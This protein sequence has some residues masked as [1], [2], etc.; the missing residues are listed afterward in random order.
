MPVDKFLEEA[1]CRKE[2]TIFLMQL[3]SS[4]IAFYIE[5]QAYK[6][7]EWKNRLLPASGAKWEFDRREHFSFTNM[8]LI[9]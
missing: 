1:I 8:S 7:R 5:S 2:K 9:F 4:K 3:A 6:L